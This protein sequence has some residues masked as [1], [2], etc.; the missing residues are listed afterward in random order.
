MENAIKGTN[1]EITYYLKILISKM[2]SFLIKFKLKKYMAF[3]KYSPLS[4]FSKQKKLYIRKSYIGLLEA[5]AN[6][7]DVDT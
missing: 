1:I 3:H 7:Y 4:K 6:S 2:A 5:C